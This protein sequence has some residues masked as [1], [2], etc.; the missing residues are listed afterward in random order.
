MHTNIS[1]QMCCV[2]TTLFEKYILTCMYVC[3]C[4][5]VSLLPELALRRRQGQYVEH[6]LRS[7]RIHIH[8]HQED[9]LNLV[10]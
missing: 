6:P 2:M 4:T 8:T 5:T 1:I 10:R 3:L 7:P 9:T